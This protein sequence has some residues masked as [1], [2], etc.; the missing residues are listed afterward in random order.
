METLGLP[1]GNLSS[2][3]SERKKISLQS[4]RSKCRQLRRSYPAVDHADVDYV[5]ANNHSASALTVSDA[6]SLYVSLSLQ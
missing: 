5:V 3:K 4:S 1:D 6:D 2:G